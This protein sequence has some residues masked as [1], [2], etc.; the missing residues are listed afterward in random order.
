MNEQQK[1]P[2]TLRTLLAEHPEWADLPIGVSHADGHVDIVDW[3]GSVYPVEH[4]DY[5]T[6]V[7]V[8]TI[9]VFSTN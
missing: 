2:A 5:V 8:D 1:P 7:G 9:L 6:L 4:Q 3:A